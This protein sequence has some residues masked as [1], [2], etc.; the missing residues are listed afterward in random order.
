MKLRNR[1]LGWLFAVLLAS[2]GSSL[3]AKPQKVWSPV[4]D[5]TAASQSFV[6]YRNDLRDTV[7]REATEPERQQISQRANAGTTRVIYPGAPLRSQMPDGAANWSP[8]PAANLI[9]QT[10]AGLRIVLHGTT[11]LDQNPTAKNAFIVAANRWEAIIS[12]PITVVIDVDYGTTFFGQ[13]YPNSS[14]LG[15][16]GLDEVTGPYSDLR[17]KLIDSASSTIEQ[18]LYNALPAS[19]VPVELDGVNS[20]VTAANLSVPNAR[21]LGIVP[22]IADPNA[23]ALGQGDAG[24]GFNSA[25]QFD[26]NPDDGISSGQVDFDAVASHEIGHALGF[27]SES[28]G[29]TA[30]PVS[31]WDLFRLRA[32]PTDLG[33]F[34]ITPRIMS[35][36][37]TQLFFPN[38][39]TTFA[40]TVLQLSTGGPEPG[41]SDGDGRQSSHWKDDALSSLRP[42]IGVMDPTLASGLRRTISENDIMA[43]DRFGYTIGAPAPVRPANDNFVSAISLQTD[44]GTLNGS[45][46]SATREQFEPN[47]V[48]L[49]GDKSVWYFWTSSLN[50]QITI[51]TIGSG[52]DTT[53]AV[54]TGP[55]VGQL[56]NVA[57]NDDIVAGTNKVSRV[58]FNITAGT[59]YRIVVD[60][61]N[62]EYGSVTL[63]WSASGTAPT[64]TPTP[65]P[66]PSPSPTPNADLAIES[67]VAS[68]NP[69][70]TTQYVNFVVAGHNLGPGTA[71]SAQ[72]SVLLPAGTSFSSCTPNCSGPGTQNG[73]TATAFLGNVAS[74]AAINLVVTAKVTASTGAVVSATASISSSSQDQ[75]NGNNSSGASAN[76]VDPVPFTEAKAI[77]LNTEGAFVLV[78]RGG[79]VWSWGHNFYGQLGD[80]TTVNRNYPAQVEGLMFVQAIGAGGNFSVALKNDGTVWTWGTNE[81]GQLGVGSTA[82]ANSALPVQVPGLFSVV[83]ISTGT[84]HTMALKSD[85]TVWVWGWNAGGELGLGAQDFGP[86]PTPVQVAGLTN[87]VNIFAGDSLSYAV[88]SDGTVWGWGFAYGGQLGNGTTGVVITSPIQLPALSGLTK[89]GSGAGSTIVMKQDNTVWSFGGNT[90]GRLGRGLPDAGPYPVPAQISGLL[91]KTLT[92]GYAHSIIVEPAGTIKVFGA[93]DTGQLGLGSFDSSAHSSPVSVPGVSD[94]FASAAGGGASLVIVGDPGAGGTIRAWGSNKFGVLG[95]GSDFPSYSPALVLERLSVAKPIFSVAAGS[96]N[97]GTPVFIA[98]GT[99]GAVI[100]YTTNGADPVESDSVIASGSSVT[101]SQSLTLKARAFKN[102]WTT[103]PVRSA[104]YTTVNF[105]NTIQ[106]SSPTVSVSEGEKSLDITLSRTGDTAG[107]ASVEFATADSAALQ[108]CYTVNGKASAR[109]DYIATLGTVGF[110]ANETSRTISIPIIDDAYAEGAETFAVGLSNPSGATLGAHTTA[111]VTINDNESV[112]GVNPISDAAFFISQHY[113]DFLNR[114]ADPAGLAFWTNSITSCGSDAQCTEVKRINGSAAFFLSIEFQQTGYLVERLYKT[115]YGD[116]IGLSTFGV[117]HQ[118]PVP[119]VRLTEFLSDTQ[120]I[121]RG[122]IVGQPGWE[123]VL[124][125]NKQGLITAFVQRPRFTSAF[126]T[127]M[128][129]IQFVTNLNMNAGN[130]LSPGELANA[131]GFFGGANNTSD[132]TARAQALRLL[133]EDQ[134]L[135][136]A[137]YNRAFV[138]MQYFGYLRRNPFELPDTDYSGYDFWLTKLNQFNGNYQN[139]EMVKAFITSSEY[140][141]RFG[142]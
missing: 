57:Q 14:I 72:L 81:H 134:D 24:I 91:A 6:L 43:L 121:G 39:V 82:P 65:S 80:G 140:R 22:D 98:D 15:A 88:K 33:T 102:G 133:A 109:C 142:P 11:Q 127:S 139:A 135:Y 41:P 21:A 111:T 99:P 83:A 9:L 101:I 49:T 131:V 45:N 87:I 34:T 77:S 112:N 59:T 31:V 141:Q 107:T 56:S 90:Q 138:L 85:G 123:T 32:T 79:T 44:S 5:G 116:D 95:I 70:A 92:S 4:A 3:S 36:G 117:P 42:Y 61:W 113:L 78:L 96:V 48:G 10:S 7:C 35:K 119:V 73:G 104:T 132:T 55:V 30:S 71:I 17:Q 16:T 125:N 62:G 74:G 136:N 63:N 105:S 20:N 58:Q 129:P 115:A 40:T 64:P 100:H 69:V 52:F 19:S 53:L 29:T 89:V 122:V 37:G 50:G 118:I 46:A 2:A 93:N 106:F 67:F 130:V 60:G 8:D 51:D 86:H 47:H 68:P 94:V 114:Q 97:P 103:S 1:L 54:Y 28:G 137:E 124:E 18:Q 110:A 120:Q 76:V 27:V 75:N 66:T 26:F 126:P 84:S 23:V 38:Q 13:P 128:T 108:G 25:F 12:T